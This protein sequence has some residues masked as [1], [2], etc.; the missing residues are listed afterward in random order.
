MT[1]TNTS[2]SHQDIRELLPWYVNGTLDESEHND[3]DAHVAGCERCS[4]DVE[5]LQK[6]RQGVLARGV[7]PIVPATTA[8]DIISA[9]I[10]TATEP[11]RFSRGLA[12]LS[13]AASIVAV[14]ILIAQYFENGVDAGNQIFETATSGEAGSS[15][16][17]ILQIRFEVS[18]SDD[19]R[20]EV[21][22]SLQG[23]TAWSVDDSGVYVV[24]MQLPGASLV[25]LEDIERKVRL[26]SE[27]QTARFVALQVPVR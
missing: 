12:A 2:R 11:R 25:V 20:L 10:G 8:A 23:T 5:V 16:D 26:L 15:I 14:G 4:S 27:V 13:A 18:V 21:V 22:R 1:A 7:E 24:Q 9:G 3:V 19:R 17:Y 6:T